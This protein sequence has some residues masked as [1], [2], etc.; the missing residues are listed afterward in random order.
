M[1]QSKRIRE[2][3]EELWRIELPVY[4]EVPAIEAELHKALDSF[5]AAANVVAAKHREYREGCNSSHDC[6]V[7]DLIEEADKWK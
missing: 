1:P 2:L 6:P 4:E 5:L 3:A 7:C